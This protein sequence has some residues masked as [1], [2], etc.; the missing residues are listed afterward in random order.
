MLGLS[1]FILIERIKESCEGVR[2]YSCYNVSES[3][4]SMTWG[5]VEI[6]TDG[7]DDD[8]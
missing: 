8:E 3:R 6:N 7:G 4:N 5:C 2:V 1:L